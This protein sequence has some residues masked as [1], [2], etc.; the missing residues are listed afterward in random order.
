MLRTG[1]VLKAKASIICLFS[2]ANGEDTVTDNP[3]VGGRQRL[4]CIG[5]TCSNNTFLN[6]VE[7]YDLGFVGLNAGS[8][9]RCSLERNTRRRV[10]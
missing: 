6:V 7:E 2:G 5:H 9:D 3:T 8:N 4:E 10:P 1:R